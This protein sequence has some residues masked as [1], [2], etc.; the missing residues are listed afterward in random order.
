VLGD[1]NQ[2]P[3]VRREVPWI[4]SR[5]Q[6]VNSARILVE[7]LNTEDLQVKYRIVKSLSRMH[8]RNPDLPGSQPLIEVHLIIQIMAYYEGLALCQAFGVK[9]GA[10]RDGLVGRALRE[11]LD[12]QLEMVFRLLGIGYPQKD[13]YFAYAALKESHKEKR[14]SAIE[15][16]DN[17]LKKDVK[18]LIIPLLE[19][20]EPEQLLARAAHFFSLRVPGRDEALRSL[21]QQPDP[22]LRACSLHAAGTYRITELQPLCR[23]LAWDQDPRVREMADWALGLMAPKNA[24]GFS[25][26]DKR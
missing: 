22:W 21:L 4:L 3:A 1:N 23:Q 18:R 26:A 14:V 25:H 5:I 8:A 20:E 6:D 17:I 12:M 15:F 16:L 11:R 10:E 19:E 13:I 7:H 2:N 24:E 9:G